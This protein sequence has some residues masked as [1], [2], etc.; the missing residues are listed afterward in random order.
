MKIC[1][2]ICLLLFGGAVFAADDAFPRRGSL[3]LDIDPTKPGA[4][5]KTFLVSR[6]APG[7]LAAALDIQVGDN[8]VYVNK[9]LAISRDDLIDLSLW[10]S[11]NK[12][13]YGPI[14]RAVREQRTNVTRLRVH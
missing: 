8:L 11:F 4:I 6:V 13:I 5:P 14:A 1:A 7:S 9:H 2:A 12:R 10:P 3:G